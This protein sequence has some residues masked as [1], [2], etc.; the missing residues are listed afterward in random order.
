MAETA[1]TVQLLSADGFRPTPAL[2]IF[3]LSTQIRA[4]ADCWTTRPST[5][6]FYPKVAGGWQSRL[7][8]VRF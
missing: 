4:I 6:L 3:L 8:N 1:H 2:V 7:I 5:D